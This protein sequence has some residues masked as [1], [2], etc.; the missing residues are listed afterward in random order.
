[1]RRRFGLS[2][3]ELVVAIAVI[4]MA[5]GPLIGVLTS[6][7]QMSNHSIHEEMSVH[8]CREITDQLL[9]LTPKVPVIVDSARRLTG[10][11][12]LTF[13]DLLNDAGFNRSLCGEETGD[14]LLAFQNM[15]KETGYRIYVSKMGE[16]FTRR[17]VRA[18]LLE[19]SS[20]R[21]LK[22]GNFW[23]ITVTVAWKSSIHEPERDTQ[24]VVIIGEDS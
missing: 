6:S 2:M 20:N 23:K 22:E 8:Y 7:N 11:R 24:V 10:N 18:E 9:R 4:A 12:R 13:A 1:M 15:G 3:A 21:H 5:V 14:G 16:V 19:A 17:K